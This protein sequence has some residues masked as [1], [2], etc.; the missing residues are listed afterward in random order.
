M[1]F[2]KVDKVPKP[3]RKKRLQLFLDEFMDANIKTAEVVWDK[4]DYKHVM[5]ARSNIGRA[6]KL[7]GHP[8]DIKQINGRIYLI[9]RDM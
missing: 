9:R 8:I 5:S 3:T 2:V 6:A 4:G 7:S 1:K